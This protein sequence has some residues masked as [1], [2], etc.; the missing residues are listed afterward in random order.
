LSCDVFIVMEEPGSY[1][2][3]KARFKQKKAERKTKGTNSLGIYI[4]E[5]G[6]FLEEWKK[7]NL[8]VKEKSKS[9]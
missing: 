2:D 6:E 5:F 8:P 9:K 3:W 7:K 4:H 1:Y